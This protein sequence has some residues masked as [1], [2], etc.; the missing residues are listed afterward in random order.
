MSKES[1]FAVGVLK[2]LNL[3]II[4]FCYY[5]VSSFLLLEN[6]F[7]KN[8]EEYRGNTKGHLYDKLPFALLPECKNN[9]E[10]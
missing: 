9:F 2:N 5:K 6:M 8:L 4:E 1:E 7:L 10:I 3:Y